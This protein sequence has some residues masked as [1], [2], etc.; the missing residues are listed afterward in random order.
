MREYPEAY[1]SYLVEFHAKRDFFECHELLEE[2]WKE[3]PD[4]P[5]SDLW[6]GL[7]QLA[8]AL[9]HERRGN[10]AGAAKMM[11]SA[12]GKLSDE[13]IYELGIDAAKL[14]PLLRDRSAML[15]GSSIKNY[16]DMNIPLVH[17]ELEQ[18][19]IDVCRSQG[20]VWHS[21]SEMTN[22]ELLD[23]HTRRDR[24]EVIKERERQ[25]ALKQLQ[26]ETRH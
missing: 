14:L 3:V 24:S 26:R 12:I 1:V 5:Y 8:V 17:K 2:Y 22:R 23:R 6:V 9:Y 19:C 11:K 25:Q 18:A 16:A 10:I 20:L 13:R 7:I 4:S 21:A 15:H